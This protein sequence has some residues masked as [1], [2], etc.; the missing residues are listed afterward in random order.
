MGP[1]FL[2]IGLYPFL[3]MIGEIY[4]HGKTASHHNNSQHPINPQADK[5]QVKCPKLAVVTLPPL[6]GG[7]TPAV[8]TAC[9]LRSGDCASKCRAE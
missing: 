1:M 7:T 8:G 9:D 4:I 5:S 3:F 6:R 2:V